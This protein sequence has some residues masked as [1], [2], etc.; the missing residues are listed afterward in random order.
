M[1]EHLD[2]I[3]ETA[4]IHYTVRLG[5]MADL[6]RARWILR[7]QC[8]TGVCLRIYCGSTAGPAVDRS[9]GFTAYPLYFADPLPA[10]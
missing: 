4:G 7:I 3:L 1:P 9:G 10:S 5:H 8:F 2:W 6:Q